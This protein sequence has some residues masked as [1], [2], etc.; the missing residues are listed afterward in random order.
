MQ[1]ASDGLAET[2]LRRGTASRALTVEEQD[3]MKVV[4]HHDKPIDG[5][6]IDMTGKR[7]LGFFYQL[8]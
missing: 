3:H 5:N 4:W 8:A 2:L 6:M 1:G 7:D